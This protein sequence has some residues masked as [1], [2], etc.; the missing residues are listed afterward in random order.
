MTRILPI[1]FFVIYLSL[2]IQSKE[3]EVTRKVE[4]KTITINCGHR[5][6]HISHFKATRAD[7]N[8]PHDVIHYIVA[9]I[10]RPTILIR[11]V[12]SDIDVSFNTT[13]IC[14]RNGQ[15]IMFSDDASKPEYSGVVLSSIFAYLDSD[16][17]VE[18]SNDPNK[19]FHNQENVL[20]YFDWT[21][22][23]PGVRSS[24]D[25]SDYFTGKPTHQYFNHSRLAFRAEVRTSDGYQ[26]NLPGYPM[27]ANLTQ[28][29]LEMVKLPGKS[30]ASNSTSNLRY[31]V[32]LLYFSVNGQSERTE[33]QLVKSIDDEYSPGV[34]ETWAI[35]LPQTR[36]YELKPTQSFV[37]WKPVGY[38]DDTPSYENEALGHFSRYEGRENKKLGD[39]GYLSPLNKKECPWSISYH[40]NSKFFGVNVTLGSA[41]DGGYAKS[42]YM[43]W[44]G[45][46]GSGKPPL[47]THISNFTITVITLGLGGP[48]VA[49]FLVA[50][51]VWMIRRL[52]KSNS[53]AKS[54][55][56]P[57]T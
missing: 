6:Y 35:T 17:L 5:E 18:L 10:N 38:K 7:Q 31:A 54:K 24:T 16:D 37:S 25:S 43:Q 27:D 39:K 53:A 57:I 33:Y 47:N 26:D 55:Y 30:M 40:A 49:G 56:E 15:S 23:S 50:I 2:M 46:V 14:N 34:F 9:A 28:F 20:D 48:F 41:K 51:F 42:Q 45:M 22:V 32:E 19:N 13:N 3:Y 21:M 1:A 29:F 44:S 52:W 11:H 12:F 36:P 4:Q 8:L